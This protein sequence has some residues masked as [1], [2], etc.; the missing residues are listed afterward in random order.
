MRQ[1]VF[2]F[3]YSYLSFFFIFFSFILFQ[4]V[5]G[6]DVRCHTP[7]CSTVVHFISRQSLIFDIILYFVLCLPL[8]LPLYLHF[9]RPPSYV[10]F[11]SSHHMPIPHQPSFMDFLCDSPHFRCPSY[12]LFLILSSF[13]TPHIHRSILISAIS[14]L[15]S[16]AFFNADVSAPYISAGHTTVMFTFPLIF[17]FIF[18]SHKPPDTLFQFFH[19]LCT[20]C[21]NSAFIAPSSANVD[22]MYVNVFTLF[23]ASRCKWISAS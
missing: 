3:P 11:L 2:S 12:Y 14:N 5:C 17:T 21:V 22:P 4:F 1:F 15:F 23:T 16:C 9:H 10:V 13:V 7:P 18:L 6:V 8:F 19:P 20:R